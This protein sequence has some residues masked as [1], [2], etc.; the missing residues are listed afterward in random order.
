MADTQDNDVRKKLASEGVTGGYPQDNGRYS[1]PAD[2]TIQPADHFKNVSSNLYLG[3]EDLMKDPPPRYSDVTRQLDDN[4]YIVKDKA[5][6]FIRDLNDKQGAD[7]KATTRPVVVPNSNVLSD[8]TDRPKYVFSGATTNINPDGDETKQKI[9]DYGLGNYEEERVKKGGDFRPPLSILHPFTRMLDVNNRNDHQ[10]SNLTTFNRY[11][12]PVSDLEHRKAFRHVFFTRPEC[13]ITYLENGDNKL[14]Q[15]AEYDEDFNTSYARMPYI[16]KLLSPVYV[17][18]TFGASG[19]TGDNFNYL[20]SNRCQGLTPSGATLSTQDAVGKSIQG[21]TITPGMHYEGRQ[22]ASISVTFR[23]TKYLEVYEYIR[24]WM[25]YIWKRK[26]GVFAPSFNGYKYAN[27]FPEAGKVGKYL[28]PFDRALDYTCSMFDFVNDESDTFPR[29]WCKYFGMYPV[30]V[31]IEG[32]GN[33]NNDALKNEM[34]VSVTFKYSYKIE[35]T[36]KSLIE[37]NYNAG[38]C[39]NLGQPTQY[40]N[41]LT[42]SDQFKY[43]NTKVK[44]AFI[45]EYVGPGAG[46]VGTPYVVL[47]NVGKDIMKDMVSGTTIAPVLRFAAIDQGNATKHKLDQRLNMHLGTRITNTDAVVQADISAAKEA[48]KQTAA[49]VVENEAEELELTNVINAK[50]NSLN[51]SLDKVDDKVDKFTDNL[52]D[53]GPGGLLI[54][55]VDK[56]F[57]THLSGS[58]KPALDLVN[59]TIDNTANT[60]DKNMSASIDWYTDLFR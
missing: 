56:L 23:D 16:C 46:F 52:I 48:A 35:N 13:Y 10:I 26:Y 24:M 20:L 22:G 11:H 19:I 2:H 59:N 3:G 33:A 36:T 58:L 32:L 18:G 15:Q 21:Y 45:R 39:D 57:G 53:H 31:Q 34:L 1:R 4:S 41:A 14:C 6:H 40:A 27:G 42:H 9:I 29:Y 17:S 12:L 50:I 44:S 49:Q 54:Q 25:L 38:I 43:V 7:P 8:T 55:G 60:V 51:Q 47:M 30:D 28:H 5:E 37:F